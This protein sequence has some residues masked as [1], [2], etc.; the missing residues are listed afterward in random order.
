MKI[1]ISKKILKEVNTF[2]Y[3]GFYLS[4]VGKKDTNV[5]NKI[6]SKS[7]LYQTKVKRLIRIQMFKALATVIII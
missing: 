3:L 4:Y 1:F 7:W 5:R 6:M 2:S